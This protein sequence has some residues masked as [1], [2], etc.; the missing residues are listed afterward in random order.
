MLKTYLTEL[1]A[2]DGTSGRE[3]A[4]RNYIL[5]KL[6]DSPIEKTVS[7]DTMGNILVHLIGESR[8]KTT[9]LFDAHMDEVGFMITHINSDGTLCFEPVGGIDPQVLFGHRVRIGKTL[10]IIGGKAIH[11]CTGEEETAV[12]ALDALAIDIGAADADDAARHISVGQWGT[13]CDELRPLGEELFIGKAV[14]DRIGCALLLT[15]ANTRLPYDLW[16]SFSVQEEVG[17]RG[18]KIV[19]ETV[20]PMIAVAIDA[21]T[22]ADTVGSDDKTCVCR[23]G[24]G[25][26]VSFADRATLYD[27]DLYK[28]IRAL[29]DEIGVPT[30]TKNRVAGG[31]NAGAIQRSHSGV[32]M[33]AI[34]LPCR[35]IHSP[36]CVGS[37]RDVEAMY[38]LLSKLAERLPQ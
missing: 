6:H 20:K 19:G 17:L 3:D 22:A 2:I 1:C 21:T 14:D 9:V 18:A 11:H 25:A 34:S 24:Q 33:A 31:N 16:L 8:A 4:V 36:S 27:M 28:E 37:R 10:G 5:Q 38:T 13:F 30:Q 23:V 12:P 29:A 35:Y 7:V 15:L 26:V 32:R